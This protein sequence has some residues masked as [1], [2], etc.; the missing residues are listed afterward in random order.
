M[1]MLSGGTVSVP[2]V[3]YENHLETLGR[4]GP[5]ILTETGVPYSK[6]GFIK[7][8]VALGTLSGVQPT[9]G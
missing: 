1:Q 6:L 3:P 5:H 7:T 2:F 8:L 4:D 9:N